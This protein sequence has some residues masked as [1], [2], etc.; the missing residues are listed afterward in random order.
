MTVL[1]IM[2][3]ICATAVL[4]LLRFLVALCS[5]CKPGRVVHLLSVSPA[6]IGGDEPD[7]GDTESTKHLNLSDHRSVRKRR[8]V[9]SP[10]ATTVLW[11]AIGVASSARWRAKERHSANKARHSS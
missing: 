10:A 5:E 2:T 8:V 7:A 9:D 1:V 6:P 11:S 4:F 3:G